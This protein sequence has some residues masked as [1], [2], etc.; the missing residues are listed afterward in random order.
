MAYQPVHPPVA[1]GADLSVSPRLAAPPPALLLS[2]PLVLVE[3][4]LA[5]Q[6]RCGDLSVVSR[7]RIRWRMQVLTSP[8]RAWWSANPQRNKG[9]SFGSDSPI[10][11]YI[12]AFPSPC[13]PGGKEPPLSPTSNIVST[14]RP[15]SAWEPRQTSCSFVAET[16]RKALARFESSGWAVRA[17]SCGRDR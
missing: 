16:K 4:H 2:V 11:I 14:P 6:R 8:G 15:R 3:I 17:G 1:R 9:D 7:Q 5:S 13:F 12:Y 10:Y